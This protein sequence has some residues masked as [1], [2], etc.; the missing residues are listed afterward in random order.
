MIRK[1]FYVI[2]T[3]SLMLLSLPKALAQNSVGLTLGGPTF[4]HFSQGLDQ[5][6]MAEVGLS[7]EYD[8]ATHIYGDYVKI[9]NHIFKNPNL[10]D[11]N[12]FFGLGGVLVITN[13]DRRENSAYYGEKSGS[14]GFGVRIPLGLEWRPPKLKE[15]GVHVQLNPVVAIVPR[16]SLEFMAGIGF[17][18]YF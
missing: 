8:H 11:V 3:L 15:L 18:Y 17:R 16:T 7:F 10:N 13:K 6:T 14:T 12:L 5:N 4:I 1:I 2:A 9:H